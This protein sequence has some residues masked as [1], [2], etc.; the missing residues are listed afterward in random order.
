[1][2]FR[3]QMNKARATRGGFA[4]KGEAKEACARDIRYGNGVIASKTS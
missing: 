2:V 1:M 3:F 4:E